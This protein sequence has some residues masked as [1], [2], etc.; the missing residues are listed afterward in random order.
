MRSRWPVTLLFLATIAAL[1]T[2]NAFA[3]LPRR[4]RVYRGRIA[5][6]VRP[7]QVQLQP[8]SFNDPLPSA[9]PSMQVAYYAPHAIPRAQR[10]EG[11]EEE[12]EAAPEFS[13][14]SYPTIPGNRAI[15]RNGVAY[16][17]ANA[18]ANVKSAIW[19]VNTIRSKPYRWGG[20]HGPRPGC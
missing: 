3:D 9:R 14:R 13:G 1:F 11:E 6:E 4:H 19:A 18:P 15:L 2:S 20:G 12:V 7:P 10:I 5:H 16:A 17:P 8:F